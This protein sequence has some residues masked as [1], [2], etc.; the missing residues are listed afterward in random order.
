M[1]YGVLAEKMMESTSSGG[2][3][4]SRG[5]ESTSSG[6]ESTS[7]RG[8]GIFDETLAALGFQESIHSL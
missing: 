3:S 7:Y 5:G 6:G 2:Q 4:T 1:T 8:T